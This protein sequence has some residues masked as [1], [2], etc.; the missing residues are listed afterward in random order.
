MLFLHL[1]LF[2]LGTQL[3]PVRLVGGS[4]ANKGRVEV[5]FNN[6]WGTVCHH[7]WDA[8]DAMVVCRQLGLPY[9]NAQPFGSATF[10]QGS[11]RIWLRYVSCG[12]SESSLAECLHSD[13]PW[14]HADGCDHSD[15]AGVICTNG[16]DIDPVLNVQCLLSN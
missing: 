2:S 15:D 6:I 10:G 9:G 1:F 12:G 8:R 3:A 7:N 14:G 11:G 16:K 5:F 13:Y 4:D